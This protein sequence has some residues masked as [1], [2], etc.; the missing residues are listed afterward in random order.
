MDVYESERVR[1]LAEFDILDKNDAITKSLEFTLHN[2]SDE[3]D[4]DAWAGGCERFGEDN[5]SVIEGVLG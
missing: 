1:A 2:T 4:Y 5:R 3:T